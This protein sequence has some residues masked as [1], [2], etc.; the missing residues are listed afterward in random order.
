M[1]KIIIPVIVILFGAA[2]ALAYKSLKIEKIPS[3]LDR[4]VADSEVNEWKQIKILVDD[5][6]LKKTKKSNHNNTRLRL[7]EIYINEGNISG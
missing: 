3:L 4:H 2:G 7:A 6:H 1:K 5:L